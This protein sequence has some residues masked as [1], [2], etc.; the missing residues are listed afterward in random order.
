MNE[1]KSKLRNASSEALMKHFL[2]KDKNDIAN[3]LMKK[4]ILFKEL[5]KKLLSKVD[6]LEESEFDFYLSI[7]AQLLISVITNENSYIKVTFQEKKILF[8]LN[9]D[10]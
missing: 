10:K 6:I 9:V 3:K 2:L 7:M 1:M 8:T 4:I 5:F